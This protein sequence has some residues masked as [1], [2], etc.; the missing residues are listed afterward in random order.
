VADVLAGSEGEHKAK[1]YNDLGVE[2][3]YNAERRLVTVEAAPVPVHSGSCR[4]GDSNAGF[5]GDAASQCVRVRA[6]QTCFR[7]TAVP[8][9]TPQNHPVSS[10]SRTT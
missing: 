7:H 3:T 6:G 8:A 1:L 9:S 2:L 4:R 10:R 5:S